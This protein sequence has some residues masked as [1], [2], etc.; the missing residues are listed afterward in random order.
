MSTAVTG[1]VHYVDGGY[2]VIGMKN[3]SA[4]DLTVVSE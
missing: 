3:P 2:N 4:P 1:E